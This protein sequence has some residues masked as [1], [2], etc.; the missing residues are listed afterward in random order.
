MKKPN[1]ILL[2]LCLMGLGIGRPIDASEAAA[3][4]IYCLWFRAPQTNEEGYAL[5]DYE[6][7]MRWMNI[8]WSRHMVWPADCEDFDPSSL[9]FE[10]P[11]DHGFG[12]VSVVDGEYAIIGSTP[13]HLFPEENSDASQD[14]GDMFILTQECAEYLMENV[15][16]ERNVENVRYDRGWISNEIDYCY[17]QFGQHIYSRSDLDHRLLIIKYSRTREGAVPYAWCFGRIEYPSDIDEVSTALVPVQAG[18]FTE[19]PYRTDTWDL[20]WAYIIGDTSSIYDPTLYN[21]WWTF[22]SV[23]EFPAFDAND[24]KRPILYIS[25]RIPETVAGFY[26][27]SKFAK[28]DSAG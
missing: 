21:E 26:E 23:I 27:V 2:L 5:K 28:Y 24:P 4:R 3:P 6:I 25:D 18:Y 8:L 10:I 14:N 1:L 20:Y 16:R 19:Y 17:N 13:I 9:D 22:V 7:S 15:A 12:V 11:E